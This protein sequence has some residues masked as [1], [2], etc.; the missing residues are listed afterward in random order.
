MSPSPQPCA[1][2]TSRPAGV[3]SR[4]VMAPGDAPQ[5]DDQG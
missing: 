5:G 2:V 4:V 1:V 3:T